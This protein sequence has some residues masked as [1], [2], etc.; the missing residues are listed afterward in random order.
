VGPSQ[1]QVTQ[2]VCLEGEPGISW[3][4]LSLSLLFGQNLTAGKEALPSSRNAPS[5]S[6]RLPALAS[7]STGKMRMNSVTVILLQWETVQVQ[8]QELQCL[9]DGLRSVQEQQRYVGTQ[10]SSALCSSPLPAVGNNDF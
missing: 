2:S 4:A 7:H 1:M 10:V 9:R 5:T 6:A 3:K 8:V